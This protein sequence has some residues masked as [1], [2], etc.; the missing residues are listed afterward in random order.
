[1][2]EINEILN[3][4]GVSGVERQIQQ[5]Q[6]E[7]RL[8][9]ISFWDIPKGA[10]ILEIGCGQGDTTAAL[11]YI[12]G[13]NGFVQGID[14]AP[15][16]YG[17]PFTLGQARDKLMKS[18]VA[19][20]IKIDF[21]TDFLSDEVSLAMPHFDIVVL[22]HCAWYFNNEN[23]LGSTLG[24]A[25]QLADRL[26]LAEWNITP[27]LPE[28][29]LHCIAVMIQAECECFQENSLSNVRTLFTPFDLLRVA[30][31]AGWTVT[32]TANVFSPQLQ[33]G[34]WEVS[35]TLAEYPNIVNSIEAMPRKLKELLLSRIELLK[36]SDK[37]KDR[38]FALD[39]FAFSGEH[40][41]PGA[42]RNK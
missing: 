11:A 37:D 13:D 26:C 29:V 9:L 2:S 28:Q 42:S 34:A 16:S 38:L 22:S 24:K 17:T 21:E 30:K 36:N 3:I 5:I 10:K 39:T 23:I 41:F 15:E 25:R 19:S 40:S 18:A 32:K 27:R 33:D 31:E 4:M 20:H 12:V 6:T 35:R 1:M 14:T 8:K 7:E